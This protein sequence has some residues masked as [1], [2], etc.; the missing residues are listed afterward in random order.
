[1]SIVSISECKDYN[2]NEVI[3]KVKESLDRLPEINQI[4]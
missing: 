1:M 3:T 2:H 4:Y